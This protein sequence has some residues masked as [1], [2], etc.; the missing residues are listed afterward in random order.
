MVLQVKSLLD[1]ARAIPRPKA[2]VAPKPKTAASK[3]AIEETAM[4]SAYRAVEA[5]TASFQPSPLTRQQNH[6]SSQSTDAAGTLRD[7]PAMRKRPDA[8]P[9]DAKSSSPS[10]RPFDEPSPANTPTA[11]ELVARDAMRKSLTGDTFQPKISPANRPFD[12]RVIDDSKGNGT[13]RFSQAGDSFDLKTSGV[14]SSP[15]AEPSDGNGTTKDGE[16]VPGQHGNDSSIFRPQVRVTVDQPKKNARLSQLP[17]V[18]EVSVSKDESVS[19]TLGSYVAPPR[20]GTR[21]Y[22]APHLVPASPSKVDNGSEE[23]ENIMYKEK[24][25]NVSE[26]SVVNRSQETSF[27]PDNSLEVT[28]SGQIFKA[29][30]YDAEENCMIT[31]TGVDSGQG[32]IHYPIS[33]SKAGIKTAET[34]DSSR[35]DIVVTRPFRGLE[36]PQLCGGV[37]IV[38]CKS[39]SSDKWGSE[40]VNFATGNK[41][42]DELMYRARAIL[43]THQFENGPRQLQQQSP[44]KLA[45]S[46]FKD[47]DDPGGNRA[48]TK[49]G[50]DVLEDGMAPLGGDWPSHN[51]GKDLSIRDML[52]DPMNNL[53]E[54]HDEASKA[55]KVNLSAI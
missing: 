9:F 23:N 14:S 39:S 4:S 20:A 36:P 32:K 7:P 51:K 13:F 38:D 49:L 43:Q 25:A 46:R 44:E 52:E 33:W 42:R 12:E 40:T 26:E 15:P 18:L 35:R 34:G 54:I 17:P 6:I 28:I 41:E 11:A 47:F 10:S 48:K 37:E 5:V 53:H 1:M 16:S 45:L 22:I 2:V 55:L 21:I 50:H 24:N 19:E 8:E 27:E 3:P 29:Y 30:S 31:D